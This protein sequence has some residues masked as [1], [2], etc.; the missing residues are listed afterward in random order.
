MTKT[1]LLGNS[2]RKNIAAS[3]LG[4]F[5]TLIIIEICCQIYTLYLDKQWE[6]IKAAPGHYYR[7]SH[8]TSL[9]YELAGNFSIEKDNRRLWINRFGIREVEHEIYDMPQIG[10][11]GD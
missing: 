2:L 4:I 6:E 7:A 11:L 8:N 1:I 3:F 9:G 5:L 10:I